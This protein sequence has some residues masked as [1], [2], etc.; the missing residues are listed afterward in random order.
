MPNTG[1]GNLY[2]SCIDIGQGDCTVIKCPNG[3]TLMIDCGAKPDLPVTRQRR[4]KNEVRQLADKGHIDALLLTHTDGDHYNR[5]PAIFGFGPETFPRS[6]VFMPSLQL[7]AIYFGNEWANYTVDMFKRWWTKGPLW[8]RPAGGG[9]APINRFVVD[10][11][12]ESKESNL[13]IEKEF[14]GSSYWDVDPEGGRGKRRR[15]VEP[16]PPPPP[17]HTTENPRTPLQLFDAAKT[18]GCDIYCLAANVKP[19]NGLTTTPHGVNTLSVV[20]LLVFGT[21]RIL[22]AGDATT[23]TEAFIDEMFDDAWLAADTLRVAHH[24]RPT[25]SGD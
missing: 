16:P 6:K 11:N 21:H 19:A 12:R 2:V 23:E 9:V 22:I 24:G 7:G 15:V 20:T 4:V 17:W 25:S 8:I 1:D 5:V 3:F 14:K 10:V 18:G 13:Y